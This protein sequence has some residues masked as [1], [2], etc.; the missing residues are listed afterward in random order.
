MGTPT[1][2]GAADARRIAL[3]AQGLAARPADPPTAQEVGE[4]LAGLGAVQADAVNTLVRTQY[5][6]VF[7]RLGPFPLELLDEVV[8]SRGEGFEYWGHALSYL[9]IDLYP[10]LRWRMD[11]HAAGKRW[12]ELQVRVESERPG[13]VAAV[14]AEVASRGPLTA[15]DLADPARQPRREGPHADW[16]R[17]SDGKYVL[18][19]LFDAGIVASAGRPD[20][21]RVYDLAERV[22]PASA[23]EAAVPDK[24]TAQRELVRRA[25]GGLGVAGVSEVADYFRLPKTST[26]AR[27]EELVEAG[28]LEAAS[29]EGWHG[30]VFLVPGA[31]TAP[32]DGRALLSPFD[33]LLWDRA[34]A[35]RIFGFEHSF[36]I[37]VKEAA[38]KYGYYVL[39]FLLGEDLCARVDL[40]ADRKRE[41]LLV[42]AAHLEP[43]HDAAGVS[44]ALAE[45]LRLMAEWLGLGRVEVGERGTLAA[46]LTAAIT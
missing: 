31:D 33:S 10:A 15:R 19:G 3:R 36:E 22:I 34:R 6:T 46:P 4:L 16:F 11:E 32:V 41:T 25:M 8:Y 43:G 13:Y 7:S 27:L 21:E 1:E 26:R 29:V 23:R 39:P 30:P 42:L 5:L 12:H 20:F 18:E 37:Y 14:A 24:T 9:P 45:E 40:K 35:Q 2:V 17:R 38:R 28:E 44:D